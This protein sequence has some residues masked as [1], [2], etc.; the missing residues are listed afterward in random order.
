MQ[1]TPYL[2]FNGNCEQAIAFYLQATE[3]EL[4]FKMT[5][6]DMPDDDDAFGSDSEITFPAELIMHAHL[7]IGQGEIMMSDGKPSER[8]AGYAV[9]L[10][11]PDQ[12]QGKRW[13][14]HLSEGGTITKAWA[15][16]FWANGFGMFIDKFGIPWMVNAYK[17]RN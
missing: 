6:G 7:R 8:H 9:S 4:L 3:G 13:F 16:T 12:A 10:S 14:D 11:T 17:A 15:P 2:F 1:I 5:F